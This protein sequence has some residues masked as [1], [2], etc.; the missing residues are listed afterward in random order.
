M[1]QGAVLTGNHET[2]VEL[3][4]GGGDPRPGD[5]QE[6]TDRPEPDQGRKGLRS[7]LTPSDPDHDPTSE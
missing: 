1:Q 7:V 3:L 4:E 5:Q 2:R 6:D